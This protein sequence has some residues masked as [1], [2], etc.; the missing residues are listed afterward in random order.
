MAG[1][2]LVDDGPAAWP[3]TPGILHRV[4]Q[5]HL[6]ALALE[7][8]PG[9]QREVSQGAAEGDD[10]SGEVALVQFV[11]LAVDGDGGVAAD[12]AAEADGER[13]VDGGLVEAGR[14]R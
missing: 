10:S 4:H 14:G 11:V 7:F 2:G 3:A 13:G 9:R 5:V 6:E 8:H 1:S 12:A